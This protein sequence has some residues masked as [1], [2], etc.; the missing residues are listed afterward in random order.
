MLYVHVNLECK[1]ES[2]EEFVFLIQTPRQKSVI[3]LVLPVGVFPYT[4]G[5]K[6]KDISNPFLYHMSW[7]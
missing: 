5:K 6:I 1:Q 2:E 3:F 7:F 4:L